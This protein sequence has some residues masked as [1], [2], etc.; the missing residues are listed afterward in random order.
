VN[1]ANDLH[2]SVRNSVA[3]QAS[4]AFDSVLNAVRLPILQELG[5]RVPRD[6]QMDV[7]DGMT[8][9]RAAMNDMS[10]GVTLA[11]GRGIP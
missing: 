5:R 4:S 9:M 8:P 6:V 7:K 11:A 1:G 3:S 10:R 2:Q